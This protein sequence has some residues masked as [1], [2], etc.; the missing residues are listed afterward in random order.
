M[1]SHLTQ[2]ESDRRY[3]HTPTRVV[4]RSKPLAAIRNQQ[5]LLQPGNGQSSVWRTPGCVLQS[6][7]DHCPGLLLDFGLELHG[8]LQIV[9]GD[10]SN[11]LPAQV[12]VRF[13]ESASEAMGEPNNDHA[14]HDT[15]LLLPWQGSVELGNTGFRFV[16]IDLVQPDTRLELREV[17]AIALMRPLEYLGEF[18]CSDERLNRIWQTGAY[19]VHANTHE[20]IWDG[21][22]RDR[23]VWLGDLHPEARVIAAAFGEIDA[24]P[25]SLDLTRDETPL[26]NLMNGMSSYSLWWVIIH[27]DWYLAHGNKAYL[28]QQR[29]YLLGLLRLMETFIDAENREC[30]PDGRFLD[31]MTHDTPD[32]K[33]AGLHAL[34]LWA[35]AAGATLCRVLGEHDQL[36]RCRQAIA[37]LRRHVPSTCGWKQVAALHALTG[38]RDPATVN[39]KLLAPNPFQ[40]LSTFYGYYV[41]QARA[42][43][44]DLPG[45][46]DLLRTYWGAML[47]L[48]ATTFWEHFDLDW[49][50]KAARIDE[51][52]RRGQ[53]DV[54]TTYGEH[55]YKGLRN[56]FCHGWAGGPT[57]WLSEHILGVTPL[58]PGFRSAR[59]L[60]Q[61]AGL[62]WVRGAMPTPHG[63][64]RVESHTTPQGRIRTRIQAPPGVKV[65]PA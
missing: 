8:A 52:P 22:K 10:I 31:W 1:M 3:L 44:G 55:C 48:G 23:L 25:N 62:E 57:A 18:E 5:A 63:L 21:I 32:A 42:L 54:H 13:G 43:A 56:S 36:R 51:L 46:L 40:N 47:D 61:L 28:K 2:P 24:V 41:L 34:L 9:T 64:I 4:W 26:P 49:I 7:A 17:R 29:P 14:V 33:H 50:K 6:T 65:N 53:I 12:R 59:V 15:R 58:Q 19:T 35:F 11:R 45:G 27:H 37:R 16:R 39:A 30:L 60:P 20:F 38:L